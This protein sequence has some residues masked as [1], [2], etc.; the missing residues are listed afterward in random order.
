MNLITQ[1]K[2]LVIYLVRHGDSVGFRLERRDGA[3][4]ETNVATSVHNIPRRKSG[5]IIFSKLAMLLLW[6]FQYNYCL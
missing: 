4:Y 5:N 1:D 3:A 6:Y 2:F